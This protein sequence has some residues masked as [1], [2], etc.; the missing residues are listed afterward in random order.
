MNALSAPTPHKSKVVPITPVQIK[1]DINQVGAPPELRFIPIDLLVI[2][3]EYQREL[4]ARSNKLIRK[5]AQNF[6]WSHL[7]ALSVTPVEGGRFEVIDGQHTAIAA[8]S[9]GDIKELPCLV[10]EAVSLK[11]RAAAFVGINQDRVAMTGLQVFW[12]KIAAG[13]ELAI[14]VLQGAE[15]AG[16]QIVRQPPTK[17]IFEPGDIIC[18]S[19]FLKLAER[20]GPIWVRR[21][22]ELG[23]K[24]GL[25][26]IKSQIANAIASLLWDN[27]DHA[28][29]LADDQI[30][31]VLVANDQ[32][33][34][35][36]QA[37]I[38]LKNAGHG[39]TTFHLAGL[40]KRLAPPTKTKE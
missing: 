14:E 33:W 15:R 10:S 11:D 24:A 17:G 34:L 22:A 28:L 31:S 26:P 36:R 27:D 37:Q 32:D 29:R 21:V 23:V 38:S 8:C 6:S 9:R 4:S 39:S 16:A 5:V 12:A 2:N 13:D 40:I 1:G 7:K 19:T 20:G 30:V 25:M 18:V 35:I 3:R